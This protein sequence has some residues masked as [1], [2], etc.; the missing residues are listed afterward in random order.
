MGV[1]A[2]TVA[3]FLWLLAGGLGPCEAVT[4]P[5]GRPDSPHFAE[6]AMMYAP[7]S[8]KSALE[9]LARAKADFPDFEHRMLEICR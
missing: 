9:V 5:S 3:D 2:S 6:F 4:V 7:E 8:K 1:V